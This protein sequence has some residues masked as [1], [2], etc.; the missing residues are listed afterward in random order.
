MT[1]GAR[2][3]LNFTFSAAI[4]ATGFCVGCAGGLRNAPAGFRPAGFLRQPGFTRFL[5]QPGITGIIR[6]PGIARIFRQPGITGS[7]R[8]GRWITP[9]R[10]FGL[11]FTCR[12]WRVRRWCHRG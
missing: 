3:F 10:F 12:Q 11:P 5:R 9:G 8:S 1:M 7:F 4:L 6:Q 2:Y